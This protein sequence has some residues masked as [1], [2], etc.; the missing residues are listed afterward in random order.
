MQAI[1]TLSGSSAGIGFAIPV[2]TLKYEVNTLI[3]D[4]QV[5]RPAIGISYLE[6]ARSKSLGIQ[7]GILVLDAP[8]GSAAYD[9][10]VK[11]TRRTPDG[12]VELGDI[13]IGIDN[14]K[15]ENEAD[16][17]KAVE[18]HKVGDVVTLKLLRSTSKDN[19]EA[20]T[21]KPLDISITLSPKPLPKL[22]TTSFKY[23]NNNIE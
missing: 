2:D 13:I 21:L 22:T 20:L 8:E 17:F 23:N 12:G 3:T 1:Y 14:D 15:I 11:G 7:S 18:K 19:D 9:A 4:G 5:L 10:G 16:L 6:A